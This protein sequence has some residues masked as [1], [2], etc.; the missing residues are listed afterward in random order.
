MADKDR[1]DT[2]EGVTEVVASEPVHK[3]RRRF[4]LAASSAPVL[5]AMVNRPVLAGACEADSPSGFDS[6]KLSGR[7][8]DRLN[9]QCGKTPDHWEN[10]AESSGDFEATFVSVF[11]SINHIQPVE[12]LD[13]NN[14]VLGLTLRD[15]ISRPAPS[16]PSEFMV[17]YEDRGNLARAFVAAYMNA[18]SSLYPLD[19]TQVVTMWNAIDVG[20]GYQVKPGVVWQKGDVLLYLHSTFGTTSSYTDGAPDTF[21]VVAS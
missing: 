10:V 20:S 11:G 12:P 1:P 4:A 15:V 6:L 2:D 5:F 21:G 7:K 19:P 14:D 8:G 16:E 18:A 9:L 13:P 3:G 17:F